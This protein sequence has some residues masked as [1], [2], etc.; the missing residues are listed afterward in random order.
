[1]PKEKLLEVTGV[2]TEALPNVMFRVRLDCNDAIIL[3][4]ASGKIRKNFIKIIEGDSVKVS[5][6]KGKVNFN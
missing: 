4:Q 6:N 3:C 1:M 5:F 2:V